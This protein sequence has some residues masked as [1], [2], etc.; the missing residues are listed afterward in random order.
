MTTGYGFTVTED[1]LYVL[2]D[3]H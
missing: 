1:T 2:L 3:I